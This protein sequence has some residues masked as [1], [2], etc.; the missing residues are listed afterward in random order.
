MIYYRIM[1]I[2]TII[3]FITFGIIRGFIGG[4]IIILGCLIALPIWIRVMMLSQDDGVS[5]ERANWAL[6]H[7]C[8]KPMRLG[9]FICGIPYHEHKF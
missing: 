6:N 7:W 4:L 1:N 5:N 9:M 8:L 2:A 3:T